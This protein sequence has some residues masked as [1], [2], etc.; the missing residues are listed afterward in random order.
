MIMILMMIQ[1]GDLVRAEVMNLAAA[2]H[3][4]PRVT[5][6]GPRQ[7][8]GLT[9][10]GP[11]GMR[12]AIQDGG[13][14]PLGETMA[15]GGQAMVGTIG[16][17]GA[18]GTRGAPRLLMQAPRTVAQGMIA[19]TSLLGIPV[20]ADGMME[21]KVPRSARRTPGVQARKW[22]SQP[23]TARSTRPTTIWDRQHGPTFAR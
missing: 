19:S 6:M 17:D 21:L 23:S 12:T 18:S 14:I 13:A 11:L 5:I 15:A 16:D 3:G 7:G 8:I 20:T 1:H 9:I 4:I 22:W 2:I 10:R